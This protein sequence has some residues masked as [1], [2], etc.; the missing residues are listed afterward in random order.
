M[1]PYYRNFGEEGAQPLIILHGL[2][3]MSDNWVSIGKHIAEEGFHVLIPDQRNHGRSGHSDVFN[4]P[5]MVD[6]LLEFMDSFEMENTLLL[7]H[8]MGG[9]TAMQFAFDYPEKVD[10]LAVVDISPSASEH[11]NTHAWIIDAL[12]QLDLDQFSGRQ[13][14]TEALRDIISNPRL[15]QFLQKN[16]YWKDRGHLGWRMNL[17]AIRNNL[18]EV[19]KPVESPDPFDKPAL[20]LRGGASDYVPDADIPLIEKLFPL[21]KVKTIENGSHWLHTEY[22]EAFTKEIVYWARNA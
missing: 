3:G 11:G 19:F 6:D 7:G 15:R 20:F 13:E 17:Q 5:A 16:L 21:A 14:V 2:F 4:Y 8:S 22:P 9:K 12:M 10:K 18:E 1:K